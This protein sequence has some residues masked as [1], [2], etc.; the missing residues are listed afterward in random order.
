M[1]VVGV[2]PGSGHF[3]RSTLDV[4]PTRAT[5]V[6]THVYDVGHK[7]KLAKPRRR[8]DGKVQSEERIIDAND[9]LELASYVRGY[10]ETVR[11]GLRETPV[12]A[13]EHRPR[14]FPTKGKMVSAE[15]ASQLKN[16]DALGMLSAGIAWMLGYRIELVTPEEWRQALTGGRHA[17]DKLVGAAVPLAI[18]GWPTRST[19]HARDAAGVALF[20][21]RRVSMGPRKPT[22]PRELEPLGTECFGGSDFP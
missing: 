20:A 2:D 19:A 17:D 15:M 18:Q 14:V 9:M 13:V 16:A 4:T 1:I 11:V 22:P 10:L 21:A 7:V 3:A 6:Y 5:F 8:K 12:F